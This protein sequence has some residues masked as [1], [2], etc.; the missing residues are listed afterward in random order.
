VA[1]PTITWCCG[2]DLID[3]NSRFRVASGKSGRNPTFTW[4]TDRPTFQAARRTPEHRSRNGSCGFASDGNDYR[5]AMHCEQ[6]RMSR[7]ERKC[8]CHGPVYREPGL[9]LAI[10]EFQPAH[11]QNVPPE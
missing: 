10:N 3:T 1:P 9:E 11:R 4:I 5:L 8:T 6:S 2:D 7:I